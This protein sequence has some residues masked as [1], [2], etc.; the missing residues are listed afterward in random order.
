MAVAVNLFR[1]VVT[2]LILASTA[3]GEVLYNNFGPGNSYE[4][5]IV[6]TISNWPGDTHQRAMPFTVVGG[7]FYL[8]TIE[9]AI[10]MDIAMPSQN[11][12]FIEIHADD[13]GVPNLT[14]LASVLV[15]GQMGFC[16]FLNPPVVAQFSGTLTLHEGVQYWV[17]ARATENSFLGWAANSIGDVG[18][19]ASRHNGE[20][21]Q[22]GSGTRSAYRVN[23]TPVPGPGVAALL[24]LGLLTSRRRHPQ[25]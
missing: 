15:D 8:D 23:G 9:M 19:K 16:G 12:V 21:W 13:S 22:T 25:A 17:A 2:S 6:S 10:G 18:L 20:P 3:S 7:D 4:Y 14:P 1:S 24:G 5:T 11:Q